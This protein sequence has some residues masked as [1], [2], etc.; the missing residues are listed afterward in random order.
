MP[1]KQ[2][3][4]DYTL[5]DSDNNEIDE[6]RIESIVKAAEIV[7]EDLYSEKSREQDNSKDNQDNKDY[8]DE[9]SILSNI[10][11]SEKPEYI[12][13]SATATVVDIT[14]DKS[15][16]KTLG[17]DSVIDISKDN[18]TPKFISLRLKTHDNEWTK[19]LTLDSDEDKRQVEK[20]IDVYGDG[21][22]DNLINSE[23]YVKPCYNEDNREQ[24]KVITPSVNLT[25][26]LKLKYNNLRSKFKRP[27]N[28][29]YTYKHYILGNTI[30]LIGTSSMIFLFGFF[31]YIFLMSISEATVSG[32][33]LLLILSGLLYAIALIF[34]AMISVSANMILTGNEEIIGDFEI[35]ILR[36]ILKTKNKIYSKLNNINKY[37]GRLLIK[38]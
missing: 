23:I 17:Q 18:Y 29:S 16:E 26:Q 4:K 2:L 3:Q 9:D 25:S 31:S 33:V 35:F 32:V 8:I 14:F 20:F 36:T 5:T 6:D 12:E 27:T 13:Y 19:K 22:L 30:Q 7:Q 1:G 24:Y 11:Y 38:N 37:L 28:K 21:R 15:F 10:E 34:Y